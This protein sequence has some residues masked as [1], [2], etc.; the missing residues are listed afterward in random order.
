VSHAVKGLDRLPDDRG[1]RLLPKGM[2]DRS[3][4][5]VNLGA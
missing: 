3:I 1:V 4:R 5:S 2:L